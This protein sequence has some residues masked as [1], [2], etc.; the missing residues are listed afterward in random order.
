MRLECWLVI[1]ASFAPRRELDVDSKSRHRLLC[2]DEIFLLHA[3]YTT[4]TLLSIAL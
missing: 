3:R 1:D 4:S 2:G